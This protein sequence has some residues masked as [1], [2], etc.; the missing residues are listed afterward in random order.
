MK[1]LRPVEKKVLPNLRRGSLFVSVEP[2]P[3]EG[4][5]SWL[6]RLGSRHGVTPSEIIKHAMGWDALPADVELAL[7]EEETSHL[8]YFANG[9]KRA[10]Q[11][12]EALFK[13]LRQK[14]I[15]PA[16]GK[17]PFQWIVEK[18]DGVSPHYGYC[19]EC[20][21]QDD[22]PYWRVEW[23][24]RH[25][26][27]CPRHQCWIRTDCYHCG[28]RPNLE[29]PYLVRTRRLALMPASLGQCAKC[30]ED[31]YDMDVPEPDPKEAEY[32]VRRQRALLSTLING[33]CYVDPY[34]EKQ[35][36]ATAINMLR[37]GAL[38]PAGVDFLPDRGQTFGDEMSRSFSTST[39][40]L[41]G[42]VPKAFA[43]LKMTRIVG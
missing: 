22:I 29:Q 9:S 32:Y 39:M 34:R 20:L 19:P 18:P 23:R 5:A 24:F 1:R 10:F 30:A 35:S 26:V 27:V 12:N 8:L 6:Q 25:W 21:R 33:F 38:H 41:D 7:S 4:I 42:V 36:I 3:H 17:G 37:M 43:N 16:R 40:I 15:Y 14:N 2:L 11:L 28:H 31:L 13:P